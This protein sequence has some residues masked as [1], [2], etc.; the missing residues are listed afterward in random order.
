M[1]LSMDINQKKQK[2]LNNYS[3]I[4]FIKQIHFFLYQDILR[5]ILTIFYYVIF[6]IEANL[7]PLWLKNYN[8]YH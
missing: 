8:Y 6:K 5:E 1:F 3:K 4:L 7:F 2:Y